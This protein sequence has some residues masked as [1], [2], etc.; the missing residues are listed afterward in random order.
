MVERAGVQRRL[1]VGAEVVPGRGVHFRIWAPDHEQLTLVLEDDGAG[2]QGRELVM[3]PGAEG[4][5]A[6]LAPD[7]RPGARY[8]FRTEGS[9]QLHQDP[10]SRYQPEGP[11]GPSQVVDPSTFAWTDDAWPGVTLK[12]QVFYEMHVGTFTPEGTWAAAMAQ[13]EEL[14][15]VGITVIEMMPVADFTGS[16]GWGYDGVDLF[17]PTRLYGEPDD[18]RRFMDKAHAVGLAVILDVVYNHVGP[19][20][21]CHR[22]F[23]ADYFSSRYENEWG[24]PLNFDGPRSGPVREF[25]ESNAAYWIEEYHFDGLR[26]DATQAMH[27]SSPE[28]ILASINRRARVAAAGRSILLVAENESQEA[29]LLRPLEEGGH[30]FDAAWNDDYHH[31]AFV[32]LTGHNEAYY[33]DHLGTAQEF[34]SA[35]KYGYLFQGQRYAWQRKGR[36]M[37]TWGIPPA[38]FVIFTEN[39]DQVANSDRG[40]RMHQRTSPGRHRAVTAMTLLG[41]GTPMLLQGQEFSASSPFLYFADHAAPLAQAVREGRH[42]FLAQF[43]SLAAQDMKGRLPDPGARAIFER[44]RLDFSER[45]SHAAAYGLHRDLLALR[46]QDPAFAAQH[47]GGLDGAVLAPQAFVLRFFAPAGHDGDRL[48]LVNL[49]QDL[50]LRVAPEPLL[51]PPAGMRWDV[52]WSS[53]DPRYDGSGTPPIITEEGMRLPGDAA[54]VLGARRQ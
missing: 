5:H 16:F 1:P 31:S 32:A 44:C 39:H 43:P 42:S 38:S 30:G 47:A 11:R 28:H 50:L 20:G 25:F 26:L 21:A 9:E 19:E 54:I 7:V 48:L 12:G 35:M 40:R 24:E 3:E 18:L 46:R 15:D 41:P 13:L 10:A 53:E 14:R 29:T 34:V 27:D 4:Y 33:S 37:P 52:I 6:V 49:G 2:G 17:A 8:R 45:A 51:A 22:T 23:A 36:G